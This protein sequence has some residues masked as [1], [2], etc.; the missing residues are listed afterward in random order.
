MS[1]RSENKSHQEEVIVMN[2]KRKSSKVAMSI[3][4]FVSEDSNLLWLPLSVLGQNP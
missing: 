4:F 3:H 1:N 2:Y